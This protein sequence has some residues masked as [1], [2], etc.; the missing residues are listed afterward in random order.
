[1][2]GILDMRIRAEILKTKWIER[3]NQMKNCEGLL[4][5]LVQEWVKINE[6]TPL[7][8]RIAK[9]TTIQRNED[10]PIEKDIKAHIVNYF[11]NQ[12]KEI[13]LFA[14]TPLKDIEYRQL[15]KVISDC[16]ADNENVNVMAKFLLNKYPGK[17]TECKHCGKMSS[18]SHLI[19]CNVKQW[20]EIVER[21]F[22]TPFYFQKIIRLENFFQRPELWPFQIIRM[23]TETKQQE[24]RANLLDWLS[25]A[26]IASCRIILGWN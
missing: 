15:Q 26:T 19:F 22:N 11:E 9:E 7:N 23:I 1:M 17:P 18:K 4:L 3:F 5:P 21:L 16:N 6:R 2:T 10:E 20:M 24:Y 12:Q 14:T 13:Q 25:K 8:D